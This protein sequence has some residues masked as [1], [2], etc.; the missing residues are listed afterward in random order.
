MKFQMYLDDALVARQFGPRPDLGKALPTY[1]LVK[2]GL[3]WK[4]FAKKYE[5]V[6]V[7]VPHRV[8]LHKINPGLYEVQVADGIEE[9]AKWFLNDKCTK[10]GIQPKPR[11]RKLRGRMGLGKTRWQGSHWL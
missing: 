5:K 3:Q 1:T 8:V 7:Q 6:E 4:Q 9:T 10:N 11:G 2:V